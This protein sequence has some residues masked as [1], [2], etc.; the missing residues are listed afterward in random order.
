MKR[1]VVY[2]SYTDH[3]KQIVKMIQERISCDVL[4]LQPVKEYSKDY[5]KVVDQ[6]TNNDQNKM[7]EI[8]K[9]DYNLDDYDEIIIGTP[10]WWYTMVPAI[11]TFLKENDLTGKII[12]PFATNAGWLGHTFEDIKELCPNSKVISPMN[13]V[14]DSDYYNLKPKTKIEDLYNW[15]DNL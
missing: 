2:F 14:F 9:F 12:R 15:I 5:Q 1:L 6:E 3:T 4:E 10:V 8:K 13:I 7:I 11:R